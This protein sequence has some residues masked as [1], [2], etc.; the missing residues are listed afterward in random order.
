MMSQ[1]LPQ[2]GIGAYVGRGLL[3]WPPSAAAGRSQNPLAPPCATALKRAECPPFCQADEAS[4]QAIKVPPGV[5]SCTG[6]RF[7]GKD[8]CMFGVWRSWRGSRTAP[9]AHNEWAARRRSR[10]A[11]AGRPLL[12][13][14]E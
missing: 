9:H 10:D 3:P 2:T 6:R 1:D 5:R 8:F 7:A 14:G 4:A 13:R 11:F 12:Q